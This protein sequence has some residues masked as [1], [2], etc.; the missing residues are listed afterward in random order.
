MTAEGRYAARYAALK[1]DVRAVLDGRHPL[2]Y[3]GADGQIVVDLLARIR[4]V[5]DSHAGG[6]G[7]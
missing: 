2:P 1:A 5:L 4:A 3:C 7:T 6:E